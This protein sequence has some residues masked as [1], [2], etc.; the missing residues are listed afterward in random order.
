MEAEEIFKDKPRYFFVEKGHIEYEDLY[1]AIGI[2]ENGRLLV[3]YFILKP[4]RQ[5]L[6]ISARD[7][8]PKEKKRYETK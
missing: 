8:A 2:T 7:A 3:V 5:A 1:S 6:V 4:G